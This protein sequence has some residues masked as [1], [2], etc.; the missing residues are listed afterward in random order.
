MTIE[1]KLQEIGLVLPPSYIPADQRLYVEVR[2]VEKLAYIAGHGPQYVNPAD[3][4][5]GK[6]GADVTI[7][8]GYEAARLTALSMLGSLKR[9]LGELERIDC[10]VKLFGMVNCTPDFYQQPAVI[11][12]ASDLILEVFG[13]ERGTHSRSAVGMMSLPGNIPVEIEGVVRLK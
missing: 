3:A 4:V 1:Q 13:K 7:E 2:V 6:L 10:W 9:E 11:N 8:Q 5:T 12:G